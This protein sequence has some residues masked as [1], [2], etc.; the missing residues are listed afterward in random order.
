MIL[1]QKEIQKTEQFIY[2]INIGD[3]ISLYLAELRGVDPV[4]VNVID[5]LKKELSKF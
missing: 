4:E 1:L 5:H 2:L 3:W